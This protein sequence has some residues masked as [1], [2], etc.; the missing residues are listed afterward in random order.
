M[1]D[2]VE[3]DNRVCFA[4]DMHSKS[5]L[6]ANNAFKRFFNGSFSYLNMHQLLG[7]IAPLDRK[8]IVRSYGQMLDGSSVKDLQICLQTPSN[9]YW[10][11]LNMHLNNSSSRPILTGFFEDISAER[12]ENLRLRNY[13]D[14]KSSI[15]NILAHDL[16]GPLGNIKMFS[17]FLNQELEQGE[18]MTSRN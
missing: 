3:H 1:L 14:N 18:R 5:L 15:S 8:L 13:A 11:K 10:I 6:Y 2:M 4:F 9:S 16:A 17:Q 12:R 7:Y